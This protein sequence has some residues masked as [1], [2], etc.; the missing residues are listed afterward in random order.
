MGEGAGNVDALY[1][2]ILGK[3]WPAEGMTSRSVHRGLKSTAGMI[4]KRK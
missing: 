3:S 2:T 1:V 4:G